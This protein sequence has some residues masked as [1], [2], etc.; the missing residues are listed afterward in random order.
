MGRLK[1]R[2]S[3]GPW[4]IAA[5]VPLPRGTGSPSQLQ[6]FDSFSRPKLAVTGARMLSILITSPPSAPCTVSRTPRTG[7]PVPCPRQYKYGEVLVPPPV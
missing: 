3:L 7:Y 6:V 5:C 4:T 1:S 2:I